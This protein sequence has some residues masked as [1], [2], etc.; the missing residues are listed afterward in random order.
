[1]QAF[2]STPSDPNWNPNCDFNNDLR[3]NGIDLI[4]LSQNWGKIVP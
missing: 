1:M 3:V 4:I 2:G